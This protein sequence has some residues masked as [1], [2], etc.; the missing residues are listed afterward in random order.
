MHNVHLS[1]ATATDIGRQIDKVLKGLGNPEPPLQLDDVREL[2]RLDRGYYSTQDDSFL[3]E[4]VSRMRVASKQILERPTLLM[5]VVRKFD[6][7]ALYIP[8]RKRILLD[9]RLIRM[10]RL[11]P[12]LQDRARTIRVHRISP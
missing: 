1:K 12:I 2:L 4:T 5:E 9:I 8:D 6:L 11:A 10:R 3:R 7:R